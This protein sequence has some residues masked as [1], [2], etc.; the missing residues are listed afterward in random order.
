MARTGNSEGAIS[1]EATSFTLKIPRQLMRDMITFMCNHKIYTN[2]AD[3]I[4]YAI[5]WFNHYS[6]IF[7]LQLISS[8]KSESEMRNSISL[9]GQRIEAELESY[10]N[11]KDKDRY[12][13][14]VSFR[15]TSS[16]IQ[17]C[18]IM[19]K[20]TWQ[21]GSVQDYMR[22][23]IAWRIKD[24]RETRTR[25]LRVSDKLSDELFSFICPLEVGRGPEAYD[26]GELM[27]DENKSE[28][29]DSRAG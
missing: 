2:R 19:N 18:T 5:R 28:S 20:Q 13:D 3:F 9:E 11:Y 24:L 1:F 27:I 22:A 16:L 26:E 4:Q 25:I 8:N 10:I 12:P 21:L 17:Y 29:N 15:I 7:L 14:H 6:L 23:A